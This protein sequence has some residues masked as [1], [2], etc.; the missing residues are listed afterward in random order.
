[1]I[2]FLGWLSILHWGPN[3]VI[4]PYF[5]FDTRYDPYTYRLTLTASLVIYATELFSNY[6]ARA[7]C[8]LCY[9]IDVTNVRLL[10]VSFR[11]YAFLQNRH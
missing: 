11:R 7:V 10:F 8:W 4:Y 1:M 2:G 9:E 6:L 3:K 5:A